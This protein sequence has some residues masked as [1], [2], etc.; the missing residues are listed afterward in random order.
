MAGNKKEEM[1]KIDKDILAISALETFSNE[2]KS[3]LMK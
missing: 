2:E 3:E 1:N